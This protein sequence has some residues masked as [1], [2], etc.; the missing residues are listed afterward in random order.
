MKPL[1]FVLLDMRHHSIAGEHLETM[2]T[3]GMAPFSGTQN[4]NCPQ[5]LR[6]MTDA[7]KTYGLIGADRMIDGAAP[8][9]WQPLKPFAYIH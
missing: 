1:V 8:N 7:L 2:D 6:N 3:Q 5:D 9:P 4:L